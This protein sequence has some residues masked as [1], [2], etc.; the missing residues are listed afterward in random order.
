MCKPKQ[1]DDRIVNCNL[2]YQANA[3]IDLCCSFDKMVLQKFY[4]KKLAAITQM[5]LVVE[6]SRILEWKYVCQL[7]NGLT[8][9]SEG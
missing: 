9:N 5:V 6:M 4:V 8:E 2:E 3:G 7:I 1:G